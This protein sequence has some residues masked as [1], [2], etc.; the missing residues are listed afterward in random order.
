ME[1][2]NPNRS[3]LRCAIIAI[4]VM[5]GTISAAYAA[6]TASFVISGVVF[7]E[8]G[9][10][11]ND[12]TVNITNLDTSGT[13]VAET[14]ESS[15]DYQMVL[16]S[17]N[18]SVNDTL[19]FNAASP[20][21]SQSSVTEHVVTQNELDTGGFVYN[22]SLAEPGDTTPPEITSVVLDPTVSEPN[23]SINVTVNVTDES[24][25]DTVTAEGVALA[26]VANDT[27]VGTITASGTPGTYNVTV[28]ATDA[29]P[30]GNNATDDSATYTIPEPGDTT[31]PTIHSVALDPTE[32]EPNGSINVTVNVT[33]DSGI[34]SVTAEGVSL[35]DAGNDT[36][37][38][39][40]TAANASGTYNVTVVATDNSTNG[41]NATDDSATYTVPEPV[42]PVIISIED[43]AIRRGENKTVPITVFDVVN[44]SGCEITFTYDPTVVYVTDVARGDMNFSFEYNVN[45]GSGWMRANA[46]D[47]TGRSGDMIFAYVTL[48][49]VGNEGDTSKMEFEDSRLVNPSFGEIAHIRDNGTFEIVPNVPP[50]VTNVSATPDTILYDNGRPR[51]PGT[52]TSLL[53][54]HVTDMDGEI[55]TVTINLSSIGGL[56]AQP[57][58]HVSGD[59]WEV[60][61]NAR[62]VAINAPDFTHQLTIAAT[63][64]NGDIN[65]SVSIELTALKRGDVTGDGIVDRMDAEYISRY[66]VGLE[67][68]VLILVGDVVGEAGDPVGDGVV[69][70]M[71]ALYIA[72]YT[73]GIGEP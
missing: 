12:P 71:D 54:A 8:N 65:D 48:T 18:V 17:D 57:M 50:E 56:P 55:T 25:I 16:D 64:D 38:G 2:M 49:A 5:I 20:D 21:E 53:S 39:T 69:D 33:D 3:Y 19:Q 32:V 58:E 62:E 27:Y 10:E 31:P 9:S 36:W 73:N 59:L 15:N 42:P 61:T 26:L 67:P 44:M 22:I 29:S 6:P 4:V 46:L 14:N 45:N 43:V 60:T 13:W 11:C 47:V 37:A 72:K 63:D 40:I 23:G 1:R 30:N 66:L 51:T 35:A 52:N 68:E 41:N 34:A 28:V 7:Y 24:G 70:L